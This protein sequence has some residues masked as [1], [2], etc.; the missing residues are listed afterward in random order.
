MKRLAVAA[1]LCVIWAL[2][3]CTGPGRYPVSGEACGPNDPVRDMN[4][5]SCPPV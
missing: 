4:A 5:P 1:A 3:A 2:G